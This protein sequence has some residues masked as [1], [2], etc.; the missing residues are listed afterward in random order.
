MALVRVVIVGHQGAV[1][2]DEVYQEGSL[3]FRVPSK[4]LQV[5]MYSPSTFT[6]LHGTIP[7]EKVNVGKFLH[8]Y[9]SMQ[10]YLGELHEMKNCLVPIQLALG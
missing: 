8:L 1:T 3:S 6:S 2:A 9:V 10:R 7:T 4:Q 5:S